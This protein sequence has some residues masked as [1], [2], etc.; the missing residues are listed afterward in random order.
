MQTIKSND[1]AQVIVFNLGDERYGVDISQVREIIRPTQITRIPNAPDFVE[2]VINL[3]GQITTIINLRKRFG[4][5][6]KEIDNDT[7]IIVVE[8]ENAVIG[9]M[10]DTVNEVKYLSSADIEALPNMITARNEAKFL[11]G[12]GK[13]PDGL[14]ILIDLNKVL[15]EDEMEK[16]R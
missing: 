4:M 1:T 7:R 9:M 8:N 5:Q 10:V 6:P 16:L 12:V 11:K 14:L 13:F 3:R 15:S 2:G